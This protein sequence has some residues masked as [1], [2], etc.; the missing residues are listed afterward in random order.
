LPGNALGSASTIIVGR[1]LGK[2]EIGQ[3]ERQLRHIFWL[4]TLGLTAIA[5]GTAPLAGVL[6]RSIPRRMT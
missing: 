4:S 1:R 2:G 5:W 3:A 6:P